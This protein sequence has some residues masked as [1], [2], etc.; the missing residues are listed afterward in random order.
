MPVD[1]DPVPVDHGHVPVERVPL[2]PPA[3]TGG[4]LYRRPPRRRFPVLAIVLVTA[5]GGGA[6]GAVI[7]RTVLGQRTVIS[8]LAT[9]PLS[10]QDTG[11]APSGS[12]QQVAQAVLP[13]V[14]SVVVS[15]GQNGG[16]GSGVV[17]T[18]DG[19]ILTNN[20]VVS[21]AA[22]GGRI[23]VQFHDGRSAQA[24]IVGRDP[25][26]DL[27]VIKAESVSG[28]RPATFGRS[29]DLAVGQTVVAI[30]SPLGL[31]G[32]VTSGIVSALD[33]PV[34]TGDAQSGVQDTVIDAIQTDAAINPG[35]SGGPL[36]NL[37]G[38]V[39]GINSAIASLGQGSGSQSGSIGLGFAIPTDEAQPIA[40]QLAT[41]G[42]ATHAQLGV[43]VRDADGG[44]ATVMEVTAGGPA[45][46][47]GLRTG[48][49]VTKVEERTIDG[50]DALVAAVRSH[51]PGE[52]IVVTYVRDGRPATATATLGAQTTS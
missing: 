1:H 18:S 34:R 50:A 13:S 26:T 52:R 37:R 47:A 35:N 25:L 42:Q 27:A 5:V 8:A 15:A 12:V 51:R 2:V 20:H 49:V 29:S 3:L 11:T 9:P 6:A 14:V 41:S 39:V 23:T 24:S 43:S 38:Y 30:G 32:T 10:I 31:S 4:P 36:V 16:E 45:D 33:R 44:G 48:D 17:L 19:L 40:Q 7:D 21:S 22:T 46:K 28:L